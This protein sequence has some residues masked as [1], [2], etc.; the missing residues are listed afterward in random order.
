MNE[1]LLNLATRE[2]MDDEIDKSVASYWVNGK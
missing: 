1:P 2:I